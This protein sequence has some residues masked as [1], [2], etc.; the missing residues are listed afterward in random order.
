MTDMQP[1]SDLAAERLCTFVALLTKW[2]AA[3]NLVSPASL[4][5]VWTRH[6]EDSAQLL[7]LVPPDR[8]LWV[9]MGAGAGFPGVVIALMTADTADAVEMV[10]IESD[11]RKAA[12]LSTVSRE[13]GVPMVIHAERIEHVVPQQ[14]DIVSARALAPLSRLCAF[15]DRH[16]A[17][18]G[19]ALFPKGGQ[20]DAE[21]AAARKVWA[22]DLEI[23][24]STTDPAGVVLKLKDLR[25]V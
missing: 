20:Y 23:H 5:D 7:G 3:I 1:Y 9:D 16:L 15:A 13:T 17:A 4:S 12:F 22:F 6:V 11:Q 8:K 25:R 2:T 14:A 21:V 10:L 24:G 18:G 19:T